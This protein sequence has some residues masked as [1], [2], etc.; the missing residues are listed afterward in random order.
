MSQKKKTFN[1]S[2]SSSRDKDLEDLRNEMNHKSEEDSILDKI[3]EKNRKTIPS[4]VTEGQLERSES[5]VQTIEAKMDSVVPGPS[6]E[7]RR[8]NKTKQEGRNPVNDLE[9]C[10]FRKNEKKFLD[11]KDKRNKD[12]W[13]PN[14]A[15]FTFPRPESDKKIKSQLPNHPDNVR[16]AS[17]PDPK[18]LLRT[19]DA[20]L[21]HIFKT[22]SD[23]KRDLTKDEKNIV[24]RVQSEKRNI[25][26]ACLKS[27]Q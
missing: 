18:Q 17:S 25:L 15:K 23:S 3:M 16:E 27:A 14:R 10:S 21:F 20:I 4:T 5:P 2:K 12:Y 26:I 1:I 11:S 8:D 22:A 24:S 7:S 19:A 6:R 9:D 13:D